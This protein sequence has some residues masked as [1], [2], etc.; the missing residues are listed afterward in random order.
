M[1]LAKRDWKAYKY[2]E[3]WL[4]KIAEVSQSLPRIVLDLVRDMERASRKKAVPKI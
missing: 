4:W 2:P 1:L 3:S